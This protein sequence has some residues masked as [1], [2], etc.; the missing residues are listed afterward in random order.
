ME[1]YLSVYGQRLAAHLQKNIKTK[2]M[3]CVE[4]LQEILT[5]LCQRFLSALGHRMCQNTKG[6]LNIDITQSD[7]VIGDIDEVSKVLERCQVASAF[8]Q[9]L[10]KQWQVSYYG[11]KHFNDIDEKTPKFETLSDVL[12]VTYAVA[13]VS[14]SLCT[15]SVSVKLDVDKLIEDDEDDDLVQSKMHEDVAARFCE[16]VENYY[17]S[18]GVE[19]DEDDEDATYAKKRRHD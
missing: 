18:K 8:L 12:K 17:G 19:V 16:W 7:D 3:D 10:E 9:V 5:D 13:R 11:S 1:K 4:T 6:G 2:H 14:D 15:I